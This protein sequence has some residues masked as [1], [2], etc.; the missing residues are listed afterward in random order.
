[1]VIGGS[2][3]EGNLGYHYKPL[4][5]YTGW[6]GR[7]LQ[8]SSCLSLPSAGTISMCVHT[9]LFMW[10]LGTKNLL[11]HASPT[12]NLSPHPQAGS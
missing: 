5:S 11:P 7:E 4:S 3:A 6:L 12:L 10:V 2:G 8:E 9:W 1:M